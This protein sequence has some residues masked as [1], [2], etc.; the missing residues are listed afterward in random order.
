MSK[1]GCEANII[2]ICLAVGGGAV[3]DDLTAQNVGIGAADTV[4]NIVVQLD[5]EHVGVRLA[6]NALVALDFVA[7]PIDFDVYTAPYQAFD[8]VFGGI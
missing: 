1:C 6:Y 8:V 7:P 3:N 4:E 5:D 2:L